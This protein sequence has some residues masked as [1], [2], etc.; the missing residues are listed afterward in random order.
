LSFREAPALRSG[1]LFAVRHSAD[2]N[3]PEEAWRRLARTVRRHANSGMWLEFLL[4]FLLAGLVLA[5]IG[6]LAARF[7]GWPWEVV[8]AVPTTLMLVAAIAAWLRTRRDFWND[9]D[10]LVQLESTFHL[11]S[12]L[13]AADEGVAAWPQFREMPACL[14]WRWSKV[15]PPFATG[16]AGIA[17]CAWIPLPDRAVLA[18]GPR[19]KPFVW[20]QAEA[21]IDAIEEEKVAEPEKLDELQ[22]ILDAMAARKPDE[23]YEHASLEAGDNLKTTLLDSLEALV[24]DLS[25]TDAALDRLANAGGLATEST[26]R[27]IAER[28]GDAMQGFEANPIGMNPALARQLSEL[29]DIRNLR[30][31]SPE[32]IAALR[33]Q[34]QQQGQGACKALGDG[35]G[36]LMA[37]MM[38]GQQPG[39]GGITR[40]PGEAPLTLGPESP[41]LGT[42][43]ME[44]LP[45]ADSENPAL[46]DLVGMRF[47]EHDLPDSFG[48]VTEA[49][50]T[51]GHAA[52]G[53]EAVF[54]QP[55]TPAEREIIR[56]YFQ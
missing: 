55:L 35:E 34:M 1:H 41:D 14:R 45:D 48:P 54:E 50:G 43:E 5:G 16:L 37:T 22:K 46:G 39:N 21:L 31:L 32:Q 44:A 2:M 36:K 30:K 7:F 40:G 29:G 10:A 38:V 27:E 15:L 4:P 20:Q 42:S 56:K 33:E 6:L 11:D 25:L 9:Q 3:Q 26:L 23:W 12:A 52:G 19:E 51:A 28:L 18:E 53:G 17:L 8:L 24:R 47:G 13:T 49:A